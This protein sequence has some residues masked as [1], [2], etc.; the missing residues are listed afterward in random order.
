MTLCDT[1]WLLRYR[2]SSAP[3]VYDA[4]EFLMYAR[5]TSS[6][7]FAWASFTTSCNPGDRLAG[8][9]GSA[10]KALLALQTMHPIMIQA[11]AMPAA[12][13]LADSFVVFMCSPL[14]SVLRLVFKITNCFGSGPPVLNHA[15]FAWPHK[16]VRFA[17]PNLAQ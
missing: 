15:S 13:L 10:A 2:M 11:T 14:V 5:M 17:L 8:G 12:A 3:N 1:P 16:P 7:V 9:G 4:P 6:P